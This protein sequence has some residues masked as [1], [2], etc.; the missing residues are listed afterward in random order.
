MNPKQR[1]YFDRQV[2]W[3]VERLPK[4]VQRMLETIPLHVE[5][6][7]SRRQMKE[8]R[9]DHPND[10]CGCFVGV[11]EGLQHSVQATT[12]TFITIFRC[13]IFDAA[14]DEEGYFDRADLREQIR[15]TILHELAHA[16][17]IDEEELEELGY[18]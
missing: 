9:I 6:R 14:A 10:L 2:D 15:V 5:D 7:P 17:G 13:G 18:G 16:V 8:L 1:E 11:A 3:V 12:P 4:P